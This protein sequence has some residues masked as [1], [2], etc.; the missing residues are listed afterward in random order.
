MLRKYILDP[1]HVFE[2]PP[3]ELREN[4]SFEVQ[5]VGIPEHREKFLR[6][7]VVSIVKI[8]WRRDK[9]EEMTWETKASMRKRY[10]Y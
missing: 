10:F 2:T 9:V 1:S 3:V 4:L 8:L 7:K 6:N 5:Q